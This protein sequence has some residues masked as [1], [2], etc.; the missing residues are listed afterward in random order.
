M[1]DNPP[2]GNSER[3]IRLRIVCK[4]PPDPDRHGAVFGLQDNS[5]TTNRVL[6]PGKRKPNGDLHFDC[7]VRVRPNTR[8]GD[9]NFLGDF[10]HG[11]SEKRF[12]YLGWRPKDWRPGQPEPGGP[13]WS[14]RMKVHLS[15][16][17]WAPIEE[18]IRSGGV[19]EATVEGTGKD[20]GPNCAS[21]PLLGDGWTVGK[22]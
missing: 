19:L 22:N 9:P 15:S 18:A 16:I 17:A 3:I 14:R 20:G 6:H 5:A 11:T 12:L 13:A 21:V 7:E 1:S 10:V 2:A 8:T 4:S